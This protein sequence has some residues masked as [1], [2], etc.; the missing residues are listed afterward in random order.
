MS[1]RDFLHRPAII[2]AVVS[3]PLDDDANSLEESIFATTRAALAVA[4][5]DF[6]AVDG[7]VVAGNDQYDGRAITV[8]AASASVGGVGRDILSTPSASEH[9]F[10]MGALRIAGGQYRTQLVVAWSPTEASNL[11]EVQRLAADPYFHRRLPLD[12]LAAH[13]LQAAA[14]EAQVPDVR[15]LAHL[16]VAKNRSHGAIAYPGATASTTS[17]DVIRWPIE[18][19]MVGQTRSGVVALVLASADFVT[20]QQR[21]DAA[22]VNGLGWATEASFLGD[23]DLSRAPALESAAHMAYGQA[24]IARPGDTIDLAEIS[25]AVPHH[26]LLA[27]EALGLSVRDAWVADVESGRFGRDGA[28]PVN[29]SGGSVSINPVYCNG[30]IRIAEVANQIRK[31]AGAHQ[32]AGARCGLAHAASG[33]AMQYQTVAILGRDRQKGRAA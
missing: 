23:R 11:H 30:L 7:I 5:I 20:E 31:C 6:D 21:D 8:M 22:W 33:F 26:E 4:G 14:L 18:V 19:G 17:S 16:I 24:G 2:S 15:R 27:Y 10:V 25:D 1:E 32:H 13:A 28:L 3:S 12:E 29:L 9:A